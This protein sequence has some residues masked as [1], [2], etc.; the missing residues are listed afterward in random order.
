MTVRDAHQLRRSPSSA[1][2]ARILFV[3]IGTLLLGSPLLS[4]TPTPSPTTPVE[5]ARTALSEWVATKRMISAEREAW[6]SGK[7]TIAA[8]LEV[9]QREIDALQQRIAAAQDSI[10]DAEKKFGELDLERTERKAVSQELAAGIQSL[11]ERTQKLLPRVPEPLADNVAP[12]SQR[13]PATDELRQKQSLSARYQNVIGVLNAIDKWNRAVTLKSEIRELASGRSVE[14]SVLYI[15]LGQA[16]YVGALG[17]D[18]KATIAGVGVA[19]PTGFNWRESNDLA[20]AIQRAVSIY[21]NEGL[22]TLVR[23]PVQIR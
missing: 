19:S 17:R 10:A 1:R 7:Q 22:A 18:G 12:I 8:Q 6:R 5:L 16:Y 2:N 3:A 13:L 11:E 14:V 15:G 9:V 20:P 21:K 23:L 4:Q